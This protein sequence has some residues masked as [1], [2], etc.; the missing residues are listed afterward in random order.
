M[1]ALSV[2]GGV[3][4]VTPPLAASIW[5]AERLLSVGVC[6]SALTDGCTESKDQFLTSPPP[7]QHASAGFA[8]PQPPGLHVVSVQ[9]DQQTE[10]QGLPDRGPGH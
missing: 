10:V 5:R 8:L 7:L 6:L 1:F 9:Q 2:A 4:A 3:C